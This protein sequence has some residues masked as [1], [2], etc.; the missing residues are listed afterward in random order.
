MRKFCIPAIAAASLFALPALAA[1]GTAKDSSNTTPQDTTQVE[2]QLRQDLTKAGYSDVQ[3]MPGSFLVRAKNKQGDQTEMM[4]SPHSMTE[5]TAMSTP[6]GSTQSGK[7]EN[8]KAESGKTESVSP[9]L[10]SS[11]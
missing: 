4:I 8:G 9:N 2:Q 5:I 1:N 11:K 6:G 7:A 10:Q 3:I